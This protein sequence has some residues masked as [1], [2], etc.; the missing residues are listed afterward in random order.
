ML[1]D[2]RNLRHGIIEA[3][4]PEGLVFDVLEFLC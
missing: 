2:L 3:L 1:L 4:L